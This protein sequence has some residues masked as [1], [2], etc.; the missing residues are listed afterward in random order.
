MKQLNPNLILAA[1]V[2][3]SF[4]MIIN[5]ETKG[6]KSFKQDE[7]RYEQ[8]FRKDNPSATVNSDAD[9]QSKDKADTILPIFD[10]TITGK[11]MNYRI[12]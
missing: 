12:Y 3:I 11:K 6:K 10:G 9:S 2:G 1:L 7:T 4:L 8:T 5:K